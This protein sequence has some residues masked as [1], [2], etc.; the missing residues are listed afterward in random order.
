MSQEEFDLIVWVI[1]LLIFAFL[2][3]EIVRMVFLL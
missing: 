1:T 3:V 2:W